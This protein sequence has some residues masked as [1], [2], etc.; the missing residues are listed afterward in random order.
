[1]KPTTF[2]FS[3]SATVSGFCCTGDPDID[4]DDCHGGCFT[5]PT[6]STTSKTTTTEN[7]WIFNIF[8][9]S[10]RI[11]NYEPGIFENYGC[12]G[13]GNMNPIEKTYGNP[14]DYVDRK[15]NNRKSCIKCAIEK[16]NGDWE[17]EQPM[18]YWYNHLNDECINQGTK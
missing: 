9:M 10:L 18:N 15:L 3:V 13:Q 6:W 17:R 1:M 7:P 16:Y 8:D 5:G 14:V 12:A 11:D 4:A 2:I